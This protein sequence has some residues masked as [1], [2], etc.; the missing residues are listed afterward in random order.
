MLCALT[1]IAV[2]VHNV[3]T[4]HDRDLM[5]ISSL[6]PLD[7]THMNQLVPLIRSTILT[8][9]PINLIG[10]QS[11]AGTGYG[12]NRIAME[13][14]TGDYPARLLL[15]YSGIITCMRTIA[16]IPCSFHLREVL[17]VTN[18][19]AYRAT[20]HCRY[21]ERCRLVEKCKFVP[22]EDLR[23]RNVAPLQLLHLLLRECSLS[24]LI[25]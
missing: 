13:T 2:E 19:G 1:R 25:I 9:R 4:V 11:R 15:A 17:N 8:P 24:L 21:Q 7:Y 5:R 12:V 18:T 16:C 20:Q 14:R 22:D 3:A 6:S 23:G 10:T